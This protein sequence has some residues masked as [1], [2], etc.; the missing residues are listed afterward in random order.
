MV[1]HDRANKLISIVL[2]VFNEFDSLS[3][4]LDKIEATVP[5]DIAHE[6]V[7]IDDGSVDRSWE[8]IRRLAG[9]RGNVRAARFSRNF[10]KEYAIAAGLETAQGDAVIIM[11]ADGQHPVSLIPQMIELWSTGEVDI[12]EGVKSDRGRESVS[13][14]IGAGVFYLLW[15]RLSGFDLEAASDYKLLDRRVVEAFLALDERNLFFRGMTAWLGFRRV[16]IPFEV[17]PRTGGSSGWSLFRL[18]RLAVAG[19]TGFSAAPLHLVSFAGIIFLLFAFL[20]AIQTLYVYLSGHAVTGFATVILL[21]LI[22]GSLLMFSLGIIGEY[23][24]RIYEEVKRRPRYV[25]AE[26]IGEESLAGEDR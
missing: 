10:G 9:L 19:L 11:D 13:T 23:L 8:E 17:A 16:Q 15:T 26:R 25:I 3:S 14:R 2:P 7:L 4:L 24:A 18:M 6:F 1:T 12:I 21:L 5:A 22:I 20:F